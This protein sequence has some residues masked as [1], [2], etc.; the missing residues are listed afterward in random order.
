MW[1]IFHRTMSVYIYI[2]IYV[3]V[4]TYIYIYVL[5]VCVFAFEMITFV[6]ILQYLKYKKY[7]KVRITKW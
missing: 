3:Y 4:C 1:I 7:D 5:C 2:H 6:Y